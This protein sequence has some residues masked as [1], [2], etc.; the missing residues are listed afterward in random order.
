MFLFHFLSPLMWDPSPIAGQANNDLGLLK[1]LLK[2][3]DINYEYQKWPSLGE[4]D[5][6]EGMDLY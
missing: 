4:S 3:W 2:I 1:T 6:G 5:V